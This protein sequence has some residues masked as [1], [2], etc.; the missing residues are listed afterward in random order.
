MCHKAIEEVPSFKEP[1][2]LEIDATD[3]HDNNMAS[4]LLPTKS[5]AD[6]LKKINEESTLTMLISTE[7][8]KR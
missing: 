2:I 5:V 4:H 3:G 6:V 1:S 7:R 8:T